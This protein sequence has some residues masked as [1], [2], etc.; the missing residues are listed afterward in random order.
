MKKCSQCGFEQDDG[1]FCGKCGHP[2]EGEEDSQPVKEQTKEDDVQTSKESS[3]KGEE[4]A[5]MAEGDGFSQPRTETTSQKADSNEQQHVQKDNE[6]VEQMKKT[7][8]EFWSYFTYYLKQPS[9]IFTKRENEF[10]NGILNLVVMLVLF[11]LSVY[12]LLKNFMSAT[13]YSFEP[14]VPFFP[15]FGNTLFFT[16]LFILLVIS[17][18][19]LINKLFGPDYSFKEIISVYGGHQS[20]ASILIV[21][22]II[23]LLVKANLIGMILISV[24]FGLAITSTPLYLISSLLTKHPKTLDPFYGYLVY[25]VAIGIGFFILFSILA[26]SAIGGLLDELGDLFYRY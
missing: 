23:L 10:M 9:Q 22:A 16:A 14:S 12:F 6:T 18:L 7:S 25:T 15:V 5:T 17:I 4:A 2:L 8:K 26:D 24:V 3:V 20:L 21:A 13:M 19:F 1:K 11:S